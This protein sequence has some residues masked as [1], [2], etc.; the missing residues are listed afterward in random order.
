[1][2]ELKKLQRASRLLQLAG[3]Y[4]S[5]AKKLLQCVEHLQISAA[6]YEQQAGT[7]ASEC[8]TEIP[9]VAMN[10]WNAGEVPFSL[11]VG[12]ILNAKTYDEALQRGLNDRQFDPELTQPI[13]QP[14]EL[15][16]YWLIDRPQTAR[17][18][19]DFSDILSRIRET[20]RR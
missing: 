7:L 13:G 3:S 19:Y 15:S 11:T 10:S 9:G 4:R 17:P 5:A 1:M 8:Q 12:L 16:E 18:N 2:Y 6:F 14:R 20:V